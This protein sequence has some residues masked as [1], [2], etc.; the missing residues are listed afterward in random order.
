MSNDKELTNYSRV[1]NYGFSLMI[2]ESEYYK[3]KIEIFKAEKE[4]ALCP[5]E[6]S[7]NFINGY[8]PHL[9]DLEK[10]ISVLKKTITQTDK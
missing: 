1:E 8:K 5:N 3:L 4:M 10:S 9:H 7:C 6:H 2:L